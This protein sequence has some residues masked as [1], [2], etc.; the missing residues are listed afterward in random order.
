M[1]FKQAQALLKKNGQ[2]HLLR[3]WNAI[4]AAQQEKLLAQIAALDFALVAKMRALLPS[5]PTPLPP[6]PASPV[7]PSTPAKV[8]IPSPAQRARAAA[9]GEAALRNGEVG[10]VLVA[11]GQGTRLGF[12][13]PKGAYPIGPVSENT[14]LFFYHARRVLAMSRR[15]GKPLPLYI[16]TSE[17]NDADTRACFEARDFFGLPPKDV[18][19]FKQRMWPAL[20]PGGKIILEKPWQIFTGPNGHGGTVS[21]L[22][23]T[24]M[25]ADMA[26][27][28]LTTLFYFQVD[29]PLVEI[30][31]PAFIGAH[32]RAQA[33][34]SLKLCEKRD[35]DEGLGVVVKRGG[36]YEMVEYTELTREQK[37]RR[38]KNG[39]LYFKYG[40]VA[41]HIFSLA[42]LK[43]QAAVAMPLHCAH[44]KIPCVDARGKCVEPATPN[45]YKFEKFIFDLLPH[46]KNVVN[47]AFDRADE[48]SPLKNA[49]GADSAETCRRDLSAK[50]ARMLKEAGVD[51]APGTIL[52]L[53]PCLAFALQ[54]LKRGVAS[55][56]ALTL[57]TEK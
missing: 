28:G 37:N 32:L 29:N 49:S 54:D 26:K 38:A 19:F 15:Y 34:Y 21:A 23:K 13:G 51:V 57:A 17:A 56:A 41:I 14:P 36:H 18:C 20:D 12:K 40:S 48:F 47:L 43:K 8:L 35:P 22:H 5:S 10:V 16:M 4:D 11:G 50:A 53:D 7:S 27:R 33:D 3:F 25:L 46:A 45:G 6:S 2:E 31:D 39:D 42:F 24:G 9:L 30:A 52:E 44:K 55:P 1:T